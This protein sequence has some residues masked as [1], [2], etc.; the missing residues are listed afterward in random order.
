MSQ[1]LPTSHFVARA[2]SGVW[3]QQPLP[4]VLGDFQEDPPSWVSW[5][6]EPSFPEVPCQPPALQAP[7]VWKATGLIL[8]ASAGQ[9]K[10]ASRI[11]SNPWGLNETK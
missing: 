5:S 8:T 11:S 1:E 6:L 4:Q 10:E 7:L 3:A 9:Q 2:R